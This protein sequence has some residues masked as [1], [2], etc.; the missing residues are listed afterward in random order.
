VS[1]EGVTLRTLLAPVSGADRDHVIECLR[2]LNGDVDRIRGDIEA[3]LPVYLAD[4]SVELVIVGTSEGEAAGLVTLT[5]FAMPRYAG[6]GYE[7][8]EIAML[9]AF[10]GR[11][12]GRNALV[13]LAER[14]GADKRARKIVVRTNGADAA[15]LYAAVYSETDMRSFQMFVNKI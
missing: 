8:E 15:R 7:I 14:L 11:G 12:L 9:P 10:R 1:V 4:P 13:A 6:Y 2:A 5:R 3:M